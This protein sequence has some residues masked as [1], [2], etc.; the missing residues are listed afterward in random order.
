VR[1][2]L[3]E[4]L[5]ELRAGIA[6][7]Y[8]N[9]PRGWRAALLP[10]ARTTGDRSLYRSGG[11]KEVISM[12]VKS[13]VGAVIGGSLVILLLAFLGARRAPGHPQ[14]A[15][16][17]A[18]AAPGPNMDLGR[19]GTPQR[20]LRAAPTL[21]SYRDPPPAFVSAPEAASVGAK[22][23]SSRLA[24]LR[25]TAVT[26]VLV[27]PAAFQHALPS[28]AN[29]R[30]VSQIVDGLIAKMAS[31]PAYHVECRMA[32]CRVG[33]VTDPAS[34]RE[35]F[36]WF[37]ALE[38][39]PN[40]QA[41]RGSHRHGR[42]DSVSTRDAL[43]GHQAVQHWLYFGLPLRPDEEHPLE[44][45]AT[46]KSC[47]E[48]VAALEQGMNDQSANDSQ[49]EAEELKRARE[50]LSLP[51]NPELTRRVAA[52]FK[53][54]DASGGTDGASLASGTWQCRGKRECRWNGPASATESF[55]RRI[56]QALAT[57]GIQI[58]Q[59]M[60][61]ANDRRTGRGAPPGDGVPAPGSAE[62][63]VVLADPSK[64]PAQAGRE[65][66]DERVLIERTSE[67]RAAH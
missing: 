7:H 26:R 43:T 67:E 56:P 19:P 42:I 36:K 1:R 66:H 49:R 50:F 6:R 37:K 14:G 33:V 23:C 30:E 41:L 61:R 38:E 51:V 9:D 20:R 31:A 10:L 15:S 47:A 34:R 57:L 32:I 60:A 44:A 40:F 22:D 11:S 59:V 52:A 16:A 27:T 3:S 12:A 46:G 55:G 58:E 21:A 28:P 53:D 5:E 54:P 25:R 65:T 48:R 64:P 29:Q 39:E 8:D 63:T 18:T 35:P 62:I 2:Q 24:Q 4:A 17:A 45:S 13:K